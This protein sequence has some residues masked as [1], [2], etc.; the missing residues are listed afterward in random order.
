[1][2]RRTSAGSGGACPIPIAVFPH[3]DHGTVEF[4]EQADGSRK[5]T[6]YAADYFR[7]LAD[8]SRGC[9][10]PPYGKASFSELKQPQQTCR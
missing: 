8:W 2:D 10:S 4:E 3:T 7:L 1:M 9:L 5:Y 6:G